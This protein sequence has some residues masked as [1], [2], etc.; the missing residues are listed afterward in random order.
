MT[1]TDLQILRKIQIKNRKDLIKR[2]KKEIK[3][4]KA[5]LKESENDA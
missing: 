4:L 3:E 1:P 5:L 2:S